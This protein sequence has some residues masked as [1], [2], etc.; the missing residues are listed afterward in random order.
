MAAGALDNML[1]AIQ[2]RVVWERW[3]QSEVRA[4]YYADLAH[5][6]RRRQAWITWVSLFASSGALAAVVFTLASQRVPWL[7][8]VLA[9]I[10]TGLSLYSLT[11]NHLQKAA[12]ATE[13]QLR[14]H[15]FAQEN[16][17]L[18]DAM[19]SETA[20]QR[21]SDL[22]AV[23]RELSALSNRLPYEKPR[24]DKWY[25]VVAEQHRAPFPRAA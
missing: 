3:F 13:L 4:F 20:P 23:A 22:D 8:A 19:Y 11:A 17:R 6:Y 1:T 18:W 24:M 7:P 25:D 10:P 16:R 21:F 2:E 12:E 9:L 14:W 15:A 5:L